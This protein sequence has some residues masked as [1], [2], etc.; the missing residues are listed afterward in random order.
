MCNSDGYYVVLLNMVVVVASCDSASG[1]SCDIL[2]FYVY[3]CRNL[4]LHLCHHFV[5]RT[6]RHGNVVD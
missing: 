5:I 6:I 4:P 2:S 1:A 3:Y